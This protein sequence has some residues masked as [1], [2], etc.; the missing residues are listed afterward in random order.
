MRAKHGLER[1]KLIDD[2]N[3]GER[4]A[5]LVEMALMAPLL[6]LLVVGVIDLGRAFFSYIAITNSAREGARYGVKL[7]TPL[8][9]GT[10]SL[11][12]TAAVSELNNQGI[13]ASEVTVRAASATTG[14]TTSLAVSVT[15]PYSTIV[16]SIVG[17]SIITMTNSA[18]MLW[19]IQ[20]AAGP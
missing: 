7:P 3:S 10:R 11:I 15:Y 2:G 14:I 18:E 12:A 19:A 16:G 8:H 4:G 6:I 17:H 20:P 9:P 5:N 1:A 13:D